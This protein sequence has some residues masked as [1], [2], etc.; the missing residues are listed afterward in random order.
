MKMLEINSEILNNFCCSQG[1]ATLPSSSF[2][3]KEQQKLAQNYIRIC[4]FKVMNLN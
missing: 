3:S 4:F 2:F 1:L